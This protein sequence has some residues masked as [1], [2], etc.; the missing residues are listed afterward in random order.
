MDLSFDADPSFMSILFVFPPSV[1]KTNDSIIICN[2]TTK[3][4]C[5]TYYIIHR[6]NNVRRNV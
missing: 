1:A 4:T 3:N 6:N 5:R 2:D